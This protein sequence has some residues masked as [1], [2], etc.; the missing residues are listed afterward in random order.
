MGCRKSEGKGEEGKWVSEQERNE[1]RGGEKQEVGGRKKETYRMMANLLGNVSELLIES[2]VLEGLS[3][4]G[5]EGFG[6]E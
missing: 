2:S 3:E 4:H 5:V 6:C 1:I